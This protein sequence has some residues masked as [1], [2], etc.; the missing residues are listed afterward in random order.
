MKDIIESLNL[1]KQILDKT[2]KLMSKLFGPSIKEFGELFADN[3]RFRRLRNQIKI[4]NKTRELLDK[5]GL[6]SHELNLKTII[7]L[8]EKSSVEEDELLQDKWANLIASMA[9]TPENGLEPRLINTL[10]SLSALE[11]KILDFIHEDIFVQRQLKLARLLD[12]KVKK[13]TEQDILVSEI[14]VDYDNI[15][16]SFKLDDDLIRIYIDNF[17]LLGLVKYKEPDVD[18]DQGSHSAGIEEDEEDRQIVDLDLELSATFNTSD[19]FH[20]TAFGNY[21]VEQCK[22]E[23]KV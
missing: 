20:L 11:A 21:F 18:I 22:L 8:I 4:L 23:K 12:S 15:Q 13:Y 16:E 19:N 14:E 2:E 1:P 10:S 7:P 5:N 3:V 9:S 6:E 17:V